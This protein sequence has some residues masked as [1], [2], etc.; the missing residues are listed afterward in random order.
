MNNLATFYFG[1]EKY[2]D[3]RKCLRYLEDAAE[4]EYVKALHN[5]GV[6]NY[7]GKLVP[8]DEEKAKNLIR[9]AAEKGD[10]EGRIMYTE[11]LLNDANSCTFDQLADLNKFCR[12]IIAKDEEN[13][14]A[15]YFLGIMLE[16]GYGVNKQP[17]TAFLYY[18]I[19]ASMHNDSALMK[20]G[21]CY[22]NGFGVEQDLRE[23]IRCYDKAS[24]GNKE[25]LVCLG[26]F[27]FHADKSTR[28]EA[29]TSQRA[30]SS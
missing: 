8:Y 7:E 17:K 14:E 13:S 3:E 10:I 23:A 28:R 22:R 18:T 27:L 30:C 11:L 9:R 1:N 19:A 16:E 21:E 12:E 29:R 20:L 5:L 26:Y 2:R 15:Y 6:I 24:K 4:A 25:A